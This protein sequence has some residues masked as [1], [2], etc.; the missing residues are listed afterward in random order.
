MPPP[1]ECLPRRN[2]HLVVLLRSWGA[3]RRHPLVLAG[4][5]VGT[6]MAGRAAGSARIAAGCK[7]ARG[8]R[9]LDLH[10]LVVGV[11]FSEMLMHLLVVAG[12]PG[13]P[14]RAN[15]CLGQWAGAGSVQHGAASLDLRPL[16]S[17]SV[18]LHIV[19]RLLRCFGSP[20]RALGPAKACQVHRLGV[21]VNMSGG[22]AGG[23]SRLKASA[24]PP[25][26]G[27]GS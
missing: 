26:E 24:M 16:A 17:I 19:V 10:K 13:A 2:T 20:Q 12:C 25:W 9:K 3:G 7:E 1:P 22:E 23:G 18:H 15:R 8:G 14:C 5:G 6:C 21:W 11:P 27:P 4:G